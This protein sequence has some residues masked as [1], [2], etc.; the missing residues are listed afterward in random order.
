[1]LCLNNQTTFQTTFQKQLF[2]KVEQNTNK[3]Q[4]NKKQ[5]FKKVEQNKTKIKK[6]KNKKK[7][8]TLFFIIQKL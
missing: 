4:K 3:K 5:L 2:K 8:K 7:E 6:Q 1:M